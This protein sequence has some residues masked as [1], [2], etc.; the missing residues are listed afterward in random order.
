MKVSRIVKKR[1][2][3]RD[4][5]GFLLFV[6]L[7]PYVCARLWGHA[8]EELKTERKEG[9]KDAQKADVCLV[10]VEMDWGTW[11]LPMEE[12]LAY[13]LA[14]VM[15]EDYEKEALKA[16]AVLLRT[17]LVEAYLSAEQENM[18][19]L[20]E[21]ENE[22]EN[23]FSEGELNQVRQINIENNTIRRFYYEDNDEALA[24]YREAVEETA[25][26]Y[27]CYQGNPIRAAYFPLSNGRT[28]S[29]EV[30]WQTDEYPYLSSVDC[31]QDKSSRDW[32]SSV[33]YDRDT[34]LSF[35]RQTLGE[36]WSEETLWDGGSF[37]YDEAGYVTEVVY[38]E[39]N[40]T[41][42]ING[43]EFRHIFGLQSA[44]FQMDREAERVT[45]SVTGAGHG[46]GMSQYTANVKALNGDS[47][48][49]ILKF[50]F[51]DTELAKFE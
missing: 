11:E 42:S 23:V 8:G 17:Q 35:L 26:I 27:L 20:N 6:F 30:V 46:F 48:D 9:A 37:L 5:F 2:N 50:F 24:A 43:E 25:G 51:Q 16:Q 4:A 12:Y 15:P 44:S 14:G 38:T 47:Y 19:T 1:T 3:K 18:Q 21:G 13:A 45:F 29:A 36:N 32:K 28:R 39:G 10:A 22:K 31:G 34:Y 49:Q 7:L 40:Q 41:I 33:T